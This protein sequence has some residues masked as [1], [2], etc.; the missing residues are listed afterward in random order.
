MARGEYIDDDKPTKIR[1]AQSKLARDFGG[2]LGLCTGLIADQR[3]N[4]EEVRYLDLWLAE[5]VEVV[6]RWPGDVIA[7]R[8]REALADGHLDDLELAHLKAT[9]TDLVGGTLEETGGSVGAATRL[10]CDESVPI[11]LADRSFCLTGDFVFGPRSKVVRA[12][13]IRGGRIL[14]GVR[15]N[16][17]YLVVGTLGSEA[18]R[19]GSFGTK[20]EKAVDYQRDGCAIFI[21]SEERWVGAVR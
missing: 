14:P 2:L 21:V 9:L 17:D 7:G 6:S 4:A 15:K 8:I 18:Y 3:L 13:E 10:P 20:I 11:V 12:I 16:L 5:H 1:L 19:G